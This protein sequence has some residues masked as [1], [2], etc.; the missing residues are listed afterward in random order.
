MAAGESGLLLDT[1]AVILWAKDDV[2][3]SVARHVESSGKLF[4]SVVSLWEFLLKSRYHDVG[5]DFHDFVSVIS[6]LKAEVLDIKMTHLKKL[7]DL[8]FIE[9]HRDPFDRIIIVQALAEGLTLV[10]ADRR[11]PAYRKAKG[12]GRLKLLWA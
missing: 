1:Q 8:P 2:T 6:M 9:Y 3:A 4:V 12:S 7:R 11:F 10:G 5:L